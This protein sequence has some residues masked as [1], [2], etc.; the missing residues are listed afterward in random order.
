MKTKK[1]RPSLGDF[2]R[3]LYIHTKENIKFWGSLITTLRSMSGPRDNLCA[4]LRNKYGLREKRILSE[5]VQSET[6]DQ[7]V[8]E[9]GGITKEPDII[10]EDSVK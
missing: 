3:K 1:Q 5:K 8:N 10:K 2:N 6:R 4:V 9:K 7:V